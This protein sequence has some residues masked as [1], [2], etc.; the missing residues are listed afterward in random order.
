MIDTSQVE[1]KD[2]I[3]KMHTKDYADKRNRAKHAE[4]EVGDKV[5]IQQ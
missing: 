4:I 3:A 5:L 1:E 2:A